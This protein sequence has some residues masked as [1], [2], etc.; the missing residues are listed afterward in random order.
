MSKLVMRQE[1][2]ALLFLH[3]EISPES[4]QSRLPE[5]LVVDTFEDKTY[6]GLVPFT[7]RN[8]RPVW[9]PAM[10]WL[11]HFHET[12]VRVYVKDT[13]GRAGV[14]FFSLE[15]ANPIAVELARTLFKLPYHW[16]K[17]EISPATSYSSKRLSHPPLPAHCHISYSLQHVLEQRTA[18]PNTLEHFLI[19]RYTLF[20]VSGK[21][22]FAG[23]VAHP[24]YQFQ[25][26]I[27]HSIDQSL[28]HAAGFPLDTP[29]LLAHYS[30][31]VKVD[32]FGLEPV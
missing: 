15:A 22:L 8:V 3:W 19:E 29:P 14:Y 11:S 12:N 18:A 21:Q 23:R 10:P 13:S 17:M 4:V 1:W 16:A 27:L 9:A 28:T 2:H 24:P 6:L 30:G 20:S 25:K 31:G 5:G 7:M 32:V 26:A